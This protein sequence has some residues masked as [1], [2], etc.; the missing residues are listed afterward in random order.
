MKTLIVSDEFELKGKKCFL[1]EF[2]HNKM[3]VEILGNS[4]KDYLKI[5]DEITNKDKKYIVKGIE[6]YKT[7]WIHNAA[8]AV[9]EI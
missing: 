7:I 4:F 8:I 1:F 9:I 3:P 6:L 2:K 5:G